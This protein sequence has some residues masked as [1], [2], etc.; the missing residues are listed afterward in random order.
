LKTQHILSKKRSK[1][2]TN[3]FFGTEE[4]NIFTGVEVACFVMGMELVGKSK[5]TFA[6][7]LCWFFETSGYFLALL[8]AYLVIIYFGCYFSAMYDNFFFLKE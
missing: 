8:L 1:A 7:I 2:T 3:V 5:R 4:V 6:G